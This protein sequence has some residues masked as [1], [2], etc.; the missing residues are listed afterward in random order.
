VPLMSMAKVSRTLAVHSLFEEQLLATTVILNLSP[1]VPRFPS[2]CL[3]A[4]AISQVNDSAVEVLPTSMVSRNV[5]NSPLA[6]I[7]VS[8]YI[9]L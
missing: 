6:K 4:Q 2:S 9:L 5:Q 1:Q 3:L 8:C 7:M